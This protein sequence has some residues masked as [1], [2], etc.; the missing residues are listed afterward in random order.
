LNAGRIFT[1]KSSGVPNWPWVV[2]AE[3]SAGHLLIVP[4][5]PQNHKDFDDACLI[6]ANKH[7]LIT[8]DS[9]AFYDLAR[10]LNRKMIQHVQSSIVQHATSISTV[11]LERIQQGALKS[12][13][14]F[15]EHKTFIKNFLR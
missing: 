9:F 1:I 14:C 8:R 10:M 3:N 2:A 11:Q 6:D 15:G 4:I 5:V 13:N 7:P 12:L